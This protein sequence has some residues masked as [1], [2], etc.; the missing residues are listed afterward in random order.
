MLDRET[1]KLAHLK[2][3]LRHN[4]KSLNESIIQS[5]HHF[6][7]KAVCVCGGGGGGGGT[8]RR[9]GGGRSQ[10]EGGN[11]RVSQRRPF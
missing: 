5:M 4:N 2:D 1:R 11:L 10:Q 3:K 8:E 7:R 9:G 6:L